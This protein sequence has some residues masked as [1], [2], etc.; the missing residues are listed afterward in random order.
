MTASVWTFFVSWTLE[1]TVVTS[2]IYNHPLWNRSKCVFVSDP[3]NADAS[4]VNAYASVAVAF[5]SG[6]WPTLIGSPDF[7][8]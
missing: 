1:I 6:P 7:D 4:A 8:A 5:S 2:V 3:V